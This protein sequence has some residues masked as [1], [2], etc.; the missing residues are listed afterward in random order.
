MQ[1]GKKYS[2]PHKVIWAANI[3]AAA[4]LTLSYLSRYVSPAKVWWL[5]LFGLGYGTF[6]LL[7]LA[8]VLVWLW[9]RSRKFLVSLF[10]IL[11][12]IGNAFSIVEPGWFTTQPPDNTR[13]VTPIKFMSFNVRLFDLYNWFHNQE[14]RN[15]IFQFLREESPDIVCFQEFYT[16]ESAKQ[17]FRNRD[18]LVRVLGTPYSHVEYTISLRGTDHWGIATYSK[19]PIVG[20][21]AVR[22]RSKSGNIFIYTD[23]KVGDDTLRVYN[24]HLESIRFHKEDYRFI[25]NLGKDEVDQDEL[26][27]GLNIL[28][29]LR[30]AFRKRASQVETIHSHIQTSPYPVVLCGDF[31]DTPVSYTVNILSDDLKDAFRESGKG[32]GK[33]Y[34]GSFPSFRIDYI[35]HDKTLKSFGYKTHHSQLSDHFPISCYLS[36]K[37]RGL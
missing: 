18:T 14:T 1:T 26:A 21:K 5:A 6:L 20:Q 3:A 2:F 28:R 24:A 15:N 16:S 22:F 10:L 33:T 9:R 23:I 12:G 19:Y 13:Y 25:E 7:N 27:G 34:S 36:W 37:K 8:F 29:R 17:R 11:V 32:F 4:A 35:F 31:N 30:L